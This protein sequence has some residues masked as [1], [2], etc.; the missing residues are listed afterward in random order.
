MYTIYEA[1]SSADVSK[2]TGFFGSGFNHFSRSGYYAM[3]GTSDYVEWSVNVQA[4]GTYP[5]SIRYSL[6]STSPKLGNRPLE[7][8]VDGVVVLSSYDMFF[9]DSNSYWRY[10]DLVDVTFA[11][12]GVH[13]IKLTVRDQDG[14]VNVDHLR[15]GKPPAVVI[16]LNGWARAIAK[17]GLGLWDDYGFVFNNETAPTTLNARPDAPLGDAFR[18]PFGRVRLQL[19]QGAKYLDIGNPQV[20]FTGYEQYLPVNYF[21][22]DGT[23]VLTNTSSDLNQKSYPG[24]EGQEV[25]LEGGLTNPICDLV[26]P[27]A[28]EFGAPIYAKLPGD[29]GWL[30]WTPKIMLEDNGPSIN[31]PLSSSS[32]LIDGGG[33]A[34]IQTDKKVGCANV[35][36]TFLNEET[37]FLSTQSS[38]C[39]ASSEI[40][41]V[42]IELTIDNVIAFYTLSQKYV[43]AIRGLEL[44][45]VD[46]HP[47]SAASSRWK[48]E[49]STICASPTQ[50]LGTET[51]QALTSA[52][53]TTADTNIYVK[54]IAGL[55]TCTAADITKDTLGI[56]IQVEQDCFTQVHADHLN[57]YDFSGWVTNHP[58]GDYNIQKW[59]QGSSASPPFDA[60]GWY[61]DY[62]FAG[63]TTR[64]I[65]KHPMSR[66]DTRVGPPNIV[67]T[68]GRLGDTIAY[69][70]LPSSLKTDDI[71]QFFDALPQPITEGGG[72][73]TCGS[74]GEVASN[75]SLRE[76]FDVQANKQDISGTDELEGQKNTVWTEVVL[77]GM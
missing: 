69:R 19:P 25:L 33:E 56:Q 44:E 71:A 39:S 61:L 77:N 60:E 70:D 51:I 36:R 29:Q 8:S 10:S 22:F 54:D 12:S 38:A 53:N 55:T 13:T 34:S 7:L 5:L 64:N 35:Q 62:P 1:D 66:W 14:G 76:M 21:T 30:Q 20:D 72:V 24:H 27:Q 2:G 63:N 32:T 48:V 28:E 16:S 4:A 59:A 58:G 67:Y 40:G 57:V 65:P 6:G 26:P 52:L 43:Y 9:T 49:A 75:S 15:L 42:D 18:W 50:G 23:E 74:L 45:D 41:E 11:A 73:V 68:G 17:S 3:G 46:E 47:C 31:D 37:C